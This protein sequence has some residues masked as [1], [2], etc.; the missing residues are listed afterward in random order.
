MSLADGESR[1]RWVRGEKVTERQYEKT[2]CIFERIYYQLRQGGEMTNS[3]QPYARLGE[4]VGIR[5]GFE[6][7][8]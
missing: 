1:T 7:N 6:L 2:W 8:W 4:E 5:S 3:G